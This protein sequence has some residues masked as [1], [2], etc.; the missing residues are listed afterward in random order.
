MLTVHREV[1]TEGDHCEFIVQEGYRWSAARGDVRRRCGRRLGCWWHGRCALHF[2][3]RE[4]DR[5]R[6]S[7]DFLISCRSHDHGSV[8]D[9]IDITPP[10]GYR[11]SDHRASDHR[12]RH[13]RRNAAG[14]Q[15]DQ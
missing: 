6:S 5:F 8:H 12:R 2:L 9:S 4:H 15:I 13:V 11:P 14:V 7:N 10:S 3:R 1:T